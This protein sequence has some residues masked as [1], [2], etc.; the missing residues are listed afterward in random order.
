MLFPGSSSARNVTALVCVCCLVSI[1][2]TML[3]TRDLQPRTEVKIDEPRSAA[4][5]GPAAAAATPVALHD[6][7]YGL[8]SAQRKTVCLSHCHDEFAALL[9]IEVEKAQQK[10]SALQEASLTSTPPPPPPPPPPPQPCEVQSSS[11]QQVAEEQSSAS[12][13]VVEEQS[14]S[15]QQATV[16]TQSV[17]QMPFPYFTPTRF[18][19]VVEQV[20]WLHRFMPGDAEG[21]SYVFAVSMQT[22]FRAATTLPNMRVYCES[23]FNGGHSA[24]TILASNPT[25][26][27]YSIDMMGRS[28]SEQLAQLVSEK[29]G[30]RF[31]LI[32]ANVF[33]ALRTPSVFDGNKCDF[34]F[35]DAHPKQDEKTLSAAELELWPQHAASKAVLMYEAGTLYARAHPHAFHGPNS[36]FERVVESQVLRPLRVIHSDRPSVVGSIRPGGPTSMSVWLY[37][38]G[39]SEY[40]AAELATMAM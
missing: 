30:D 21:G 12:Q 18:Q 40:S 34:M 13:R 28:Y 8:T 25:V 39:A 33:D 38:A 16:T 32:R 4:G 14:S 3:W 36:D 37:S 26:K 11:S 24:M 6:G 1:G 23:G 17:E 9:K 5:L 22:L 27:V 35:S 31:K 19:H 29:Y 2:L 20:K 15:A 7:P 10:F